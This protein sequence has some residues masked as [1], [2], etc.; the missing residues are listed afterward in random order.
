MNDR[1]VGIKDQT[2]KMAL[3]SWLQIQGLISRCF[4]ALVDANG[5]GGCHCISHT[6]ADDMRLKG[7]ERIREYR[8]QDLDR[9]PGLEDSFIERRYRSIRLYVGSRPTICT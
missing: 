5:S 6:L 8:V 7:K 2:W 3:R 9:V 4:P 1:T